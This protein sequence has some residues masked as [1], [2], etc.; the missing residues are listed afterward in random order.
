MRE[1]YVEILIN[2]TTHYTQSSFHYYNNNNNNRNKKNTLVYVIICVSF[3]LKNLFYFYLG[4]K[5]NKIIKAR[6]DYLREKRETLFIFFLLVFIIQE[7]FNLK[8]E[9]FL[10]KKNKNQKR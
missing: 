8:F 7:Y 1:K 6:I 9:Y 2:I 5:K 4:K 10:K 3:L